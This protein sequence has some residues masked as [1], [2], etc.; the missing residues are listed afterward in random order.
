MSQPRSSTRS[1][2]DA[3]GAPTARKLLAWYDANRRQMPW[4]ALPGERA[5][6]YH[7]WLSEIML[8]QTTVTAV[9]PYFDKFLKLWPDLNSL[10]AASR[11]EVLTA[12]AGL[13]YYSRA[14]NLHACARVLMEE[15]G[16]A[17]PKT[18]KDL[19]TLPGIGTYTAA[20]IASIA[21]GQRATVV[22]GNVERVMTRQF[23][24][25][26]PVPRVKAEVKAL[27]EPLVPKARPGDFAQATMDLGATICTPR[28]PSCGVCPWA[29][30]C[31]ARADGD[32][33][34]YPVKAPKKDK[35][36]RRGIVHWAETKAGAVLIEQRPETGLLA[37]MWQFP[38]DD[39]AVATP[40]AAFG[41]RAR[42]KSAPFEGNW[43]RLPGLV[44]HTFTHFHLELAVYHTTTNVGINPDRG[45]FVAAADLASYALPSLMQKVVAHVEGA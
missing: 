7:V 31:Q 24:L 41:E 13:G 20:A 39:W 14:R 10:A 8:Q 45:Q 29:K 17:F 38:S 19:L 25:A 11:D 23:A 2:S 16:G 42:K 35:P 1:A 28:S 3:K 36:T 43:T 18:E 26:T 37:A 22:D 32:Q 12:W 6:P 30:S 15:H 9:T 21:F 40:R 44:T 27:L 33:L 34:S 5:E 4:R